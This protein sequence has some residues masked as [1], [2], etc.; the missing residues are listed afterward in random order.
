MRNAKEYTL[1]QTEG[2]SGT[3]TVTVLKPEP[4][5]ALVHIEHPSVNLR[6]EV[7]GELFRVLLESQD[8]V[9]KV[10]GFG[11]Q[12]RLIV[13]ERDHRVIYETP[14]VTQGT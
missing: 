10:E 12:V 13:Q 14:A 5:S 11:E 4:G 7:L 8:L 1:H 3:A 6:V 9:L 2:E